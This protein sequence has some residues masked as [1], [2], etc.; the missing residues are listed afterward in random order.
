[1]SIYKHAYH[2]WWTHQRVQVCLHPCTGWWHMGFCHSAPLVVL[3]SWVGSSVA[4][5]SLKWAACWWLRR[6]DFFLPVPDTILATLSKA[7]TWEPVFPGK[8]KQPFTQRLQRYTTTFLGWGCRKITHF[9]PRLAPSPSHQSVG[10]GHFLPRPQ[11]A[12]HGAPDGAPHRA[13]SCHNAP[14]SFSFFLSS[15]LP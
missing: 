2:V 1:M 3:W 5:Y 6:R 8:I 10:G 14:S 9:A 15:L 11:D 12:P 4:L 7:I 13:L